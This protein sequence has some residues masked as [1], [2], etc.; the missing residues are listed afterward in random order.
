[1]L[2]V[3]LAAQFVANIDTAIANIAAPALQSE[4]GASGGQAGLVVSGY[5]VAYA[6]LII[7]GARL[8]AS[9]GHRRIFV[10]GTGL[11]T[12]ASLACAL[13]PDPVFLIVS[14]ILQGAGA[15][16]MVPQVLSDIQ[17]HFTGRERVRALGYYALALSTGAIAGQALGGVLVAAD[18]FG[19][20]WRPIFLVNVPVGLVL[21]W[22]ATRTMPRDGPTGDAADVDLRGMALLAVTVL[23]V[24][25]PLLLGPETGWSA[26]TW[27]SLVAGIPAAAAFRRS[28][29]RRTTRGERPLIAIDVVRSPVIRWS[30]VAHGATTMTY[31]AL[32]FVLAL[33]L[34]EGLARGPAYAGSAM[35]AWVGAFG[36]AGPL[37]TRIPARTLPSMSALGCVVLAV[38][39]AS[40]LLYLIAG[41]RTGPALF[42]LLGI[43]GLGLG[44]SSNALIGQM[45]S[46]LP[47]RH[48]ADLSGVISTNAQL[49]GALGVA[50]FGGGYLFLNGPGSAESAARALQ[51]VLAAFVVT[52]LLSAFAAYRGR[53]PGHGAHGAGPRTSG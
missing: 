31:V 20:S 22:A 29:R 45:T 36:I 1:M 46:V 21:V 18:L 40:V 37:L 28:Q 7:T 34:Q 23:L 33:Y 17:Q 3:L 38:G 12:A 25:V 16:L 42:L 13:A 9:H 8:G 5:V 6:V 47:G 43:G 10:L 39:Y 2:A 19:T 15:A 50:V 32:L 26:W 52:S 27:A 35:V 48:A 49:C 4:L 30:L 11:F 53:A 41:N 44:I 14:R 24:V 51:A